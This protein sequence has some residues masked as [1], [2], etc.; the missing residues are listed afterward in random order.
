MM[1]ELA[2]TKE[3]RMKGIGGSDARKIVSGDWYDLWL[4]K[5]GKKESPDL[6]REFPVQLG[7][8]TES[9]NLKWFEQE[10]EMEVTHTGIKTSNLKPFMYA[11][12]DGLVHDKAQGFG[13]FEAKHLNGFVTQE[14]AIENYLP[15]I[16]HYMYVFECDYSWLSIIFGN[17]WGAYR[18]EKNEKFMKELVEKEE[19]FWSFVVQDKPP[20]DGESIETPSTK[21]LVLDKMIVKDMTQNNQWVMLSHVLSDTKNKAKEFDD[22]KKEIKSLMQP[23][24]REAIGLGVSV[25]RSKTGRLTVNI[26]EEDAK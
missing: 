10:M 13:I 9:F 22:A 24:W 21:E 12:V 6:S 25:K 5:T 14:K 7:V 2:Y 26:G 3:E 11:N 8:W 15:Q 23:D 19:Q 1:S 20:Y 17:R 4:E 18:I 16:H